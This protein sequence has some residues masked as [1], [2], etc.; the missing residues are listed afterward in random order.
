MRLPFYRF[1]GSRR[2]ITD[3]FGRSDSG[4]IRKNNEDSFAL[5]PDR[6][7]FLVADGMGGHNAGEVASRMA[8]EKAVSLCNPKSFTKRRGNKAAMQ[9]FL[10]DV[11]EQVNRKV[12]KASEASA[13]QR[14]MG[15]TLTLAYLEGSVMH[16]CHVGDSRCYLLRDEDLMQI[17]TDHVA[18]FSTDTAFGGVEGTKCNAVTRIIG[19][20]FPEDPEYH[21]VELVSGDKILL[22]SDGLWSMLSDT[23]ITR[24]IGE[25]KD[26]ER[27]CD[28]LIEQA[29][30][31]GGRDN[32]TA[33]LVLI[34]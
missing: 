5:L 26:A 3:C 14:G 18:D 19:Y 25:E 13:D 12:I 32:I 22:C 8:I 7:F 9:H 16:C 23:E 33:I 17:T 1:L 4:R 29:N 30:E 31:A 21:A 27:C 28:R 15:T 10:I 34:S 6:G 11:F 2:K 24:I 20:P